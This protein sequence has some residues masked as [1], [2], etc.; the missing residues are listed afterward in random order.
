M[1]GTVTAS[2]HFGKHLEA[3]YLLKN[4]FRTCFMLLLKS[5][6]RPAQ[7]GALK[8]CGPLPRAHFGDAV[9]DL[10]G[11]VCKHENSENSS[12]DS[13]CTTYMHAL[14][15]H[16]VLSETKSFRR[17]TLAS[18]SEVLRWNQVLLQYS[19]SV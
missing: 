10:V 11:R 18:M 5:D 9:G 4:L 14:C 12:E 13:R 3:E 8:P 7:N 2:N 6:T 17:F 16:I 1:V 19:F 15:V